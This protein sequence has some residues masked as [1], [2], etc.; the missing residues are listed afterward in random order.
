MFLG[1]SSMTSWIFQGSPEHYEVDKRL[2]ET[3]TVLWRINQKEYKGEINRGDEV[4]IWRSDYDKPGTGGIVAKGVIVSL[5]K[6]MVDDKPEYWKDNEQD[7]SEPALRVCI[8]IDDVRLS[9]DDGML[10]RTTL[11]MDPNTNE[12]RIIRMPQHTNYPI[13]ENIAQ[14]LRFL[15]AKA[16]PKVKQEL[17]K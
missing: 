1:V 12:M 11:K 3:K 13:I 7:K 14:H 10:L 16:D 5:P 17:K 8:V 4:Y 9:H 2:R 6:V 15:W